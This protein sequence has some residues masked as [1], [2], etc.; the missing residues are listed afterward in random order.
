MPRYKIF[1]AIEIGSTRVAMQI[2]KISKS[3]AISVIENIQ[4]E[5]SIGRETYSIGKISYENVDKICVC[6]EKFVRIMK[7]YNVDDYTCYATTAVR[8]AINREYIIEQI[9]IR[10]NLKV[11]VLSNEEER[12]LH[13]K[14][15]ALKNEYFDDI[16][17]KG[18]V[19]VDI[20]SGSLQV[21]YYKGSELKFSE[22]LSVGSIRI[23]EKLSELKNEMS[24]FSE[25][26][27]KYM[28]REIQ[29]LKI[30]CSFKEEYEYTLF[31]GSHI[32]NIKKLC[33]IKDTD[34]ISCENFERAYNML[35]SGNLDDI[36]FEYDI[37]YDEMEMIFTTVIIYKVFMDIKKDAKFIMA[38]T[39]LTDGICVEYA[40]K[41]G[42]THTKH[43]FTNDIL[44]SAMY[45]AQKYNVNKKHIEKTTEF[46]EQIFKE[47]SKRYNLSKHDLII[48]KTA[49]IFADT[50][51]Y[52]SSNDYN[53]Y[54]SH[55]VRATPIIGLSKNDMDTIANVVLLEENT[56]GVP[57]KR[58]RLL[59]SKLSS[60]L[61]LSKALDTEKNQVVS[62][63]KTSL[64]NNCL[65]IE[66]YSKN[67]IRFELRSIEEAKRGFEDIFGIQIE[68]KHIKR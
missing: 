7:E 14:A 61:A 36:A 19:L 28:S 12:F 11:T 31:L 17:K 25:L 50:G 2:A 22:N 48:L 53:T 15:V 39:S 47:L 56:V 37:P 63:I 68:I 65:T 34:V 1:A 59:V 49:A 54:S 3:T 32:K 44:S 5:I 57:T 60:I 58:R 46:S 43:I 8:E 35:T 6:L 13:N 4:S 41:N 21:S 29:K 66:A 67:N 9:N 62:S 55:I 24:V 27:L 51:I 30:S 64:K 23:M 16:I 42:Y 33:K 26:V 20:S 45:C 40:E 52:I 10:T 38:D 18:A